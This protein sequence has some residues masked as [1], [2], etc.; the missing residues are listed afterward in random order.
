M[1][2]E[3]EGALTVQPEE[4]RVLSAV[5]VEQQVQAIQ[6]VMKKVMQDGTHYGKV[7]GCGDKPTLLK[8][9]A[10]KIMMT[11]RLGGEP[12]IEDL[13]TGDNL[14]YRIRMRIFSV[15]TGKTL[16][17]GV[18]ECSSDESKYKWRSSISDEEFE[19]TDPSRRRTKYARNY[20][21][22]QVRAEVADVANTVLKIAK[23]RALVDGILT[24]TAASDIFTQ[25]LEDIPEENLGPRSGKPAVQAPKETPAEKHVI[26]EAAKLQMLDFMTEMGYDDKRQALAFQ[27]AELVGEA[28]ALEGL[29]K[30]YKE[31]LEKKKHA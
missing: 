30:Q 26:S 3:Q 13:S 21:A 14:R 12:E 23:K 24:V 22:K 9:G 2:P 29:E 6:Q 19:A 7:P 10:E 31:F 28:A 17:Y 8:P 11:F 25:D 5:E 27:R 16:G 18:G 20:T 1:G 4:P 15:L